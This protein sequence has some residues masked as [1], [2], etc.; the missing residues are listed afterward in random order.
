MTAQEIINGLNDYIEHPTYMIDL[1]LLSEAIKKLEP[2]AEK[3]RLLSEDKEGWMPIG[4]RFA[5][6]WQSSPKPCK[7]GGEE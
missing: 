6:A 1:D 3:E 4:E 2:V 5:K 7:V